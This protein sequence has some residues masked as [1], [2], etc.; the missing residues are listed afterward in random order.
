MKIMTILREIL[1]LFTTVITL[2]SS[3]IGYLS[4]I[5]AVCLIATSG[6]LYLILCSHLEEEDMGK[7]KIA[8]LIS[9]LILFLFTLTFKEFDKS[10]FYNLI[11]VIILNALVIIDILIED[12]KEKINIEVKEEVKEKE[13]EEE[14]YEIINL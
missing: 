1:F 6:Y 14:V 12:K 5:S 7:Q 11:A 2:N 4:N 3:F 8:C 10:Y 13:I 9:L